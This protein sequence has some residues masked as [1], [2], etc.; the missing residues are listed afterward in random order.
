MQHISIFITFIVLQDKPQSDK[1]PQHRKGKNNTKEVTISPV[2][3]APH[4]CT[5]PAPAAGS[6]PHQHM[7]ALTALPD[8]MPGRTL[9][10]PNQDSNKNRI[11]SNIKQN[12]KTELEWTWI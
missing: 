6:W 8:D 1:A 12:Y 10:G 11:S 7:V 9:Q 3:G 2:T 4:S 5:H